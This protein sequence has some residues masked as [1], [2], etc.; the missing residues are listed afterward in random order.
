[1]SQ[2]SGDAVVVLPDWRTDA[3]LPGARTVSVDDEQ[4]RKA[5]IGGIGD[6]YAGGACVEQ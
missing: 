2:P 6:P 5:G 3:V 1:M 4:S